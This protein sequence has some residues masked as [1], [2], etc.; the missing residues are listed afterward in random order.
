MTKR[1]STTCILSVLLALTCSCAA[2]QSGTELEE[3]KKAIA[4]SNDIYFQSF[5]KN[6]SSIFINR[7]AEDCLIMVP[8]ARVMKGREGALQF[9]KIAYNDIG[10]RNGRFLTIDVYGLGNGYVAEEGFWKSFD[11]NNKLFDD[12]K[13][14]VLWKKTPKGWKMFRDSFSSDH[15]TL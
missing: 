15:K 5:V 7:Y 9:F 1:L 10:L 2:A 13:F 8:N 3:A 12:G 14:L 4:E 11:K 6:D